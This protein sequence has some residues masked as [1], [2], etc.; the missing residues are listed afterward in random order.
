ME[1]ERERLVAAFRREHRLPSV[2]AALADDRGPV[3]TF[4]D[5][6]ADPSRD[7]PAS[8]DTVYRVG[9]VTKPFTATA[10]MQLRDEGALRLDDPLAHHLPEFARATNPFGPVED[11]TIRR[12]LTHQSGLP[13]ESPVFD[14]ASR[15]FPTHEELL[16]TLDRVQLVVPPASE[17]KYSNFGYELLG[18]VITRRSQRPYR[19]LVAERI[20]VPLGMD[21]SSFDPADAGSRMAQGHDPPAFTDAPAPS[22]D[23]M[24]ATDA[25]GGLC[26]TVEDLAHWVALQLRAHRGTEASG[27]QILSGDTL[28]E[29]HR[30]RRL[31]DA[32]WTQAI[33]LGWRIFRHDGDLR[34]GHAGGTFGFTAKIAF[35]R[36]L[37]RGAVVLTNGEGPVADLVDALLGDAVPA[38]TTA[39]ATGAPVPVPGPIRDLLGLYAWEDHS[40]P[41]AVEWVGGRLTLSWLGAG[42]RGDDRP[43]VLVG[44]GDPCVF[45]VVGGRETGETCTFRRDADGAV[46]GL[47]ISGWP[48]VRLISAG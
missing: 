14:W 43:R 28:A 41:A 19:D 42:P 27:P 2:A 30:P 26:S 44:T 39:A 17:V 31:L 24:K 16:A 29:M 6:A 37:N 11:V 4:A 22:P 12:L 47:T 18:E 15:H 5:G 21:S 40:A 25:D 33:G 20:L 38:E 36:R 10:V 45:T 9:S 8:V 32:G 1:N 48:L 23:R 3:W 35:S 34:V 7:E 46:L 13:V